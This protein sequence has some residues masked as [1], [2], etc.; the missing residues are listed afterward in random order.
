[1][2]K[3]ITFSRNFPDTHPRKGEPTYFV[4]KIWK[5]LY[6][7]QQPMINGI[8]AT[9]EGEINYSYFNKHLSE[10][11]AK[12]HTI[13]KG[14]RWKACDWFSPR[15]WSG[16]P[17]QSKMITI[18]PDMQLVRVVDFELHDTT[19]IFMDG[20]YWN[21]L[22]HRDT[23]VLAKNDGLNLIDFQNWISAKNTFSGQILIWQDV[24][25]PY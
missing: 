25:L 6:D 23:D 20:T 10:L 17:Y 7:R 19:V 14:K 13:R 2:S 8:P 18:A 16:K 24:D 11:V 1:M 22:Y 21:H 4:E 5:S 3:V 12:K 15:V 9:D